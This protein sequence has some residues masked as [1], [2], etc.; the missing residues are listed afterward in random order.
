MYF[1]HF[2]ISSISISS[3]SAWLWAVTFLVRFFDMNFGVFGMQSCGC[4]DDAPAA[5]AAP[6]HMVQISTEQT[7]RQQSKYSYTGPSVIND[8]GLVT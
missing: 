8:A 7:H 4:I 6:E 5:A 1:T 3:S 2:F